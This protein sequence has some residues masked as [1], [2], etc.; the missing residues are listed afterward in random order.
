MSV[1]EATSSQSPTFGKVLRLNNS[2]ATATDPN[3]AA[4]FH[5]I[6]TNSLVQ[7]PWR[8]RDARKHPARL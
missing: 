2:F 7:N 6:V 4:A 8:R 5:E 1:S 3:E